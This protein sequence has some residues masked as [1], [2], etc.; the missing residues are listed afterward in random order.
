MIE[1]LLAR[2][3]FGSAMWNVWRSENPDVAIILDGANLNGMILTGI[4]FSRA[5]LRGASMH[6]TNL[7]SADLRRADLTGANLAEA[8]L[9]A[10]RL[11]GA[12][13]TGANLHEADLLG[14]ELIDTQYSVEDLRGAVNV[15]DAVP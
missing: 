3:K 6:A 8:D 1:K 12:I 15:P 13:L 11:G 2:L 10:A 7:M 9:I 5:S 14:A 4:D